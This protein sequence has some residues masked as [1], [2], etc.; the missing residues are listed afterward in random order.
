[1]TRSFGWL[2]RL[3]EPG[4]AAVALTVQGRAISLPGTPVLPVFADGSAAVGAA[5]S[6]ARK[7]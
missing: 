5:F 3:L 4:V 1:M 6:P 2:C 7:D